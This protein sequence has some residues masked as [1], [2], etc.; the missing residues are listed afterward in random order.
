MSRAY[1]VCDTKDSRK[2]A[3]SLAKEGQLLLPMLDLIER[4]ETAVDEV[5]D[6]VGRGTLE[7][8]LLM[9]AQEVAGPR[10]PG[11]TGGEV[12]WHRRQPGVVTLSDRKV[13]V[14][15]PVPVNNPVLV[16]CQGVAE[17]DA[18]RHPE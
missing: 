3:E 10:H 9:S 13:R 1:Q 14:E 12:R 11:R 18:R 2:W 5:I 8:I 7:A 15:R 17:F 16:S 6:V 4:A